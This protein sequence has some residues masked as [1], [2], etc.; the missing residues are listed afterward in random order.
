MIAKDH[1]IKMSEGR[2]KS[3][4]LGHYDECYKIKSKKMT[5]FKHGRG[6]EISITHLKKGSKHYKAKSHNLVS[7]EGIEYSFDNAEHFVRTN[8]TLFDKQ[9]ILVR[10]KPNGKKYTRASNG[11]QRISN[12]D[13]PSWKGWNKLNRLDING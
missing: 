3:L 9:D 4:K 10:K 6:N 13:R 7:P 8:E 2:K 12:E 5:G 1:K 11:L